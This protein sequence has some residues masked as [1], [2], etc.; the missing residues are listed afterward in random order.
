MESK[1]FPAHAGGGTVKI[2]VQASDYGVP[3]TS[4]IKSIK[5][6]LDPADKTGLW[7]WRC[8]HWPFC[9]GRGSR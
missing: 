5:N 7:L 3:V 8:T 2:V 9:Y 4:L 6:I 1:V